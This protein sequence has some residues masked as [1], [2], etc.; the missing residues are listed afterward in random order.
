MRFESTVKVL[1]KCKLKYYK[2]VEYAAGFLMSAVVIIDV[3]RV[4]QERF[5]ELWNDISSGKVT[6]AALAQRLAPKKE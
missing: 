6:D 3:V 1:A 4:Y 2:I 5:Q